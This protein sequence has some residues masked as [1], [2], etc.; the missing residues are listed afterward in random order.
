MQQSE[1]EWQRNELIRKYRFTVQP[2][3][4][5]YLTMQAAGTS[6]SWQNHTYGTLQAKLKPYLEELFGQIAGLKNLTDER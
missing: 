1:F 5:E 6:V 3:Y 4:Q 2:I